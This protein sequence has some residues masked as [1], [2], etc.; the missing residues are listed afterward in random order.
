[1]DITDC[2]RQLVRSSGR[3]SREVSRAIGRSPTWI[4]SAVSRGTDISASRLASI[5]RACGWR[6]VLRREDEEMEVDPHA[7]SDKGTAD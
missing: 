5:A 1:M 3:S 4:A 6:L 2:I 7:D